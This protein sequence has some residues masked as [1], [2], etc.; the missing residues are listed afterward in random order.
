MNSGTVLVFWDLVFLVGR[1]HKTV[2]P[3]MLRC[4]SDMSRATIYRHLKALIELGLV[5]KA[6]YGRYTFVTNSAFVY[7]VFDAIS[8]MDKV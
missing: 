3:S 2:K 6:G 7:D 5:D 4:N 1:G 8:T